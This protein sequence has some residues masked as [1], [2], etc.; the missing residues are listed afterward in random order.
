MSFL[1]VFFNCHIY[2]SMPNVQLLQ[3][4]PQLH[5]RKEDNR[6]EMHI[7]FFLSIN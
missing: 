5:Y 4:T 2:D 3:A 6:Y 7:V 1:S